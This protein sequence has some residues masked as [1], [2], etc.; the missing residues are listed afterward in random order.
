MW[1]KLHP[2]L[3]AFDYITKTE[4]KTIA[5]AKYVWLIP[6]ELDWGASKHDANTRVV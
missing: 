3:I 6:C 1:L 4:E 2:Q 5:S